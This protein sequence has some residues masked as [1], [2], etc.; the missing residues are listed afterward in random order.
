[1]RQNLH[2]LLTPSGSKG[3]QKAPPPHARRRRLPQVSL[4]T[5]EGRSALA[6][7]RDEYWEVLE[8]MR[9]LEQEMRVLEEGLRGLADE[10][11]EGGRG[12][13][14]AAMDRA[15]GGEVAAMD[16][17]R[18]GEGA[19]M[20][21]A[22]G[23]GGHTLGAL[24]ERVLEDVSRGAG[25]AS[26]GQ[27]GGADSAACVS[28]PR[29]GR[30]ECASSVRPEQGKGIGAFLEGLATLQ[31]WRRAHSSAVVPPGAPGGKELRAWLDALNVRHAAS[32]LPAW[33]ARE[34]EA[35]GV[36]WAPSQE[37]VAW[38]EG[39]HALR[40]RMQGGTGEMGQGPPGGAACGGEGL[41]DWLE[42]QHQAAEEFRLA[43]ARA[44]AL[45]RLGV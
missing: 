20:D 33:Q 10:S 32:A 12:G 40:A 3:V 31:A 9:E 18:G 7:A 29:E 23:Q 38:A 35:S 2:P 14:G 15:R 28:S 6:S 1:V 43:P 42:Q 11:E 37:E 21:P 30:G 44:R 27:R 24:R 45:K 22:R 34:L 17:A 36:S 5:P 39:Y 16:P 41:S 19:A 26:V 4:V 8:E 25:E 13:E